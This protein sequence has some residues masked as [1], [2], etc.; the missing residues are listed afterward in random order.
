MTSLGVKID[1]IA[2]VRQARRAAEPDPVHAAVLAE[3]GGADGISVHLRGDRRHI[4]DR[5]VEVLRQVVR[6]RLTLEMAAT[7]E[8]VRMALT[9]K[10]DQVTLMP[11]RWEEVTTEGGLDAV[12]NS[13]QLVSSVKTL[14]EAGVRVSLFV[15]PELEQV[16]EAHKLGAVAIEVNTAAWAG[17][18]DERDREMAFRKVTDAAR[19]G[20]KLGLRVH[21]GHGLTYGNVASIAVVDEISRLNIGHSI[22]ARAILVGMEKAVREMADTVRS[23]APGRV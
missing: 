2:T 11:E 17:T 5:D 4:Q 3:L 10:P 1:H 22:V 18:T 23:V 12:L 8:M 19:L 15:E 7:Q 21:A 20:R 9:L 14:Q 16:K 13:V 6:T